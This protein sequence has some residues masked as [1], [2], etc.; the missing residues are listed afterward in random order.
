[1]QSFF[2]QK[3][4][5]KFGDPGEKLYLGREYQSTPITERAITINETKQY[6]INTYSTD[7]A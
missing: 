6:I 2:C 1:M 4:D 7:E 3:L 5:H